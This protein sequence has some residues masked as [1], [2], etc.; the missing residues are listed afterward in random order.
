MLYVQKLS[1]I[2]ELFGF[3]ALWSGV[4]DHD[5]RFCGD[6][7]GQL[8]RTNFGSDFRSTGVTGSQRHLKVHTGSFADF[9]NRNKSDRTTTFDGF[10]WKISNRT[11]RRDEFDFGR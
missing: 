8:V 10:R 5:G 2:A 6:G 11:S 1:M 3:A 9:R 7:I 4:E